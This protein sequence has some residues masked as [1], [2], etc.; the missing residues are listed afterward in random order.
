[1]RCGGLRRSEVAGMK[2]SDIDLVNQKLR[3]QGK[4]GKIRFRGVAG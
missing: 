3:I 2:G 1:L 4:G